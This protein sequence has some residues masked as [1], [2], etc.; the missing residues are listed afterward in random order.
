M[1]AMICVALRCV[2]VS[3]DAWGARLITDTPTATADNAATNA[4][5]NLLFPAT[6]SASPLL[7][8]P[9]KL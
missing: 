3:A 9:V 2:M 6:T 8:Q 4:A 7:D 1:S 5:L